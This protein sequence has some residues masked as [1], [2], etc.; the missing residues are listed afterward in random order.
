[1]S[2]WLCVKC[3]HEFA[4]GPGVKRQP[5]YFGM[6]LFILVGIGCILFGIGAIIFKTEYAF[7][8]SVAVL[9]GVGAI[10]FGWRL[11]TGIKAICPSC[12]KPQ[13]IAGNTKSADEIRRRGKKE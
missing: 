11:K 9:G 5:E 8:G 3:L 1:M 6:V 4:D 7:Q 13:G 12:G 10:A 2:D